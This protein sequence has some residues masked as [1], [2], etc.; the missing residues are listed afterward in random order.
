MGMSVIFLLLYVTASLRQ[1]T[2]GIQQ[3]IQNQKL[4]MQ[5][6]DLKN[7]LKM[8]D[9]VKKDYLNNEAKPE[10]EKQYKELMDKLTLLKEEAKDEKN[11]LHQSALENERKEKALNQ[12]QQMV[13]NIMNANLLAKSKIK[14]RE[15]VIGEQDVEIETQETEISQLEKDIAQKKKQIADNQNKIADA[16][17]Q[18]EQRLEDL[19]AAYKQKKMTEVAYA[20]K[21]EALKNENERKLEQLEANTQAVEKQLASVKD[22][23]GAVTGELAGVNEDLSKT[24]N[25]LAKT[26]GERKQLAG[27]LSAAEMEHNQQVAKL[28]KE[29]ADQ[30]ARE[31]AKFDG[32]LAK[33]RLSASEKA[34]REGAFRAQAAQKERELGQKLASLGKDLAEKEGALGKTKEELGRAAQAIKG[35]A[36]KIKEGEALLAKARA[37][38]DARKQISKD[39]KQGFKKAGVEADVN[40]NTGEV[41]INFGDVYFDNDSAKLK[42]KMK[43]TLKKAMPVYSKSLLGN[44]KVSDKISAIEIIGFASP[45]YQGKYVDPKNLDPKTGHKAMEHNLDLSYRRAKEIFNFVTDSRSIEFD[46]QKDMLPLMKVTGKSFLAERLPDARSP[47]SASKNSDFCAIHDC[48][49]AQRV[50]IKFSFEDKK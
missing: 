11:R 45:T 18:L 40:E 28:Q 37:E 23:L 9:S 10:E 47:G 7:Q 49:K 41:V 39:I 17:E 20:K 5:V 31:R 38:A 33:E 1:G 36:S 26:E 35:Q 22:K 6:E 29:F 21:V 32:Q 12:Y 34:R 42:E 2:S 24:K 27:Q 25:V 16:N 19:K 44:R 13:R 30:A 48:R 46:H 50:I 4:T 14:T 15:E 8:Y 3:Q 43:E